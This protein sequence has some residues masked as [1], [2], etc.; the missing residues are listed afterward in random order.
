MRMKFSLWVSLQDCT[1][2]GM[3]KW[4]VSHQWCGRLD[5]V[6][7]ANVARAHPIGIVYNIMALNNEAISVLLGLS[8]YHFILS[9]CS[10]LMPV[11]SCSDTDSKK[12]G[13]RCSY[14]FLLQ[15]PL[16]LQA[17]SKLPV[18]TGAIRLRLDC[19]LVL[20]NGRTNRCVKC[21]TSFGSWSVT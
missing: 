13:D 6:G 11:L 16:V 8:L 1:G 10:I 12:R 4:R 7:N 17:V 9:K 5:G 3:R 2:R 18:H 15:R 20:E 19:S 14:I 21:F